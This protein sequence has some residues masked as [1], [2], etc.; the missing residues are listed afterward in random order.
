MP[1]D[2]QNLQKS[3]QIHT[4]PDTFSQQIPFKIPQSAC[5]AGSVPSTTGPDYA[6]NKRTQPSLQSYGVDDDD[7]LN[8]FEARQHEEDQFQQDPGASLQNGK[9]GNQNI[10][11]NRNDFDNPLSEKEEARDLV[12]EWE[13]SQSVAVDL[14]LLQVGYV[15]T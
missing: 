6:Q 9:D 12:S 5:F 1:F 11:G 13:L 7:Y 2:L 4:S 10:L 15:H 3:Q 8:N 14:T